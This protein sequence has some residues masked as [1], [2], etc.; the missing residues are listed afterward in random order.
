[1]PKRTIHEWECMSKKSA[2]QRFL[3]NLLL[4]F[5]PLSDELRVWEQGQGSTCWNGYCLRMLV[6][7]VIGKVSTSKSNRHRKSLEDLCCCCLRD[8]TWADT[9][10]PM[11]VGEKGWETIRTN[12]DPEN[13]CSLPGTSIDVYGSIH[14]Y[15]LNFPQIGKLP[16]RNNRRINTFLFRR[17]RRWLQVRH[18]YWNWT[19]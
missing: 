10:G 7:S 9:S 5:R 16:Q 2:R 11:L 3:S 12:G 1:M 15:Q 8:S 4:L 6:Q 18:K 19:W 14:R 13:T 17:G